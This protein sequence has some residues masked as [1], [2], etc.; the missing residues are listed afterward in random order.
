LVNA[1]NY[2]LMNVELAAETADMINE[3]SEHVELLGIA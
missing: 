3:I 2:A 1:R